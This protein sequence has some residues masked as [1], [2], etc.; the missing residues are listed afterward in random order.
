MRDPE[1]PRE[2]LPPDWVGVRAANVF[3]DLHTTWNTQAQGHWAALAVEAKS[4]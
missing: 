4:S 1:L 2:L 3:T